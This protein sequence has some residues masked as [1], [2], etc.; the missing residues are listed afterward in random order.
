MHDT[1]ASCTA[2]NTPCMHWS[3]VACRAS[4]ESIMACHCACEWN[5]AGRLLSRGAIMYRKMTRLTQ[6]VE[7]QN[8][9]LT[10]H[11]CS[12]G[13]HWA[14]M[15]A[16]GVIQESCCLLPGTVTRSPSEILGQKQLVQRN[17]GPHSQPEASAEKVAPRHFRGIWHNELADLRLTIP[18]KSYQSSAGGV[19]LGACRADIGTQ[20][21]A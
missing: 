13:H 18:C 16:Q 10:L 17:L 2:G 15:A 6:G 7:H 20:W 19:D 4:S 5:F 21:A 8:N 12:T 11:P 9:I 1:G 3:N 14:T